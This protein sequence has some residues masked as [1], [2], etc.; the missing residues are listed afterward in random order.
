MRRCARELRSEGD[1]ERTYSCPFAGGPA[2]LRNGIGDAHDGG[3]L[4]LF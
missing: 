2:W 4:P 3:D 1:K